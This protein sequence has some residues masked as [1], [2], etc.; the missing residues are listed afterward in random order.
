M[1]FSE[2]LK[3]IGE[4]SNSYSK[5]TGLK[6]STVWR[7]ENEIGEPRLKTALFIEKESDGKVKVKDLCPSY[8]KLKIPEREEAA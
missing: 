6:Q 2:Y 1:K 7:L 4:S 3:S 8:K 5:R